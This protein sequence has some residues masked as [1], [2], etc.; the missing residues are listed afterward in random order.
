M[1]KLLTLGLLKK[2]AGRIA[3]PAYGALFKAFVARAISPRWRFEE[4]WDFFN[5]PTFHFFHLR[6][7][8]FHG[9]L[10]SAPDWTG[11]PRLVFIRLRSFA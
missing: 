1:G 5:S 8:R 7:A 3:R 2:S 9:I 11:S 10:L 4:K 6:D